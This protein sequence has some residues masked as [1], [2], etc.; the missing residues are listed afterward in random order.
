MDWQIDG[1]MDGTGR[2]K[3]SVHQ[4]HCVCLSVWICLWMWLFLCMIITTFPGC[5]LASCSLYRCVCVVTGT[6][7]IRV[8]TGLCHISPT[9]ITAKWSVKLITEREKRADCSLLLEITCYLPYKSWVS[10]NGAFCF[11]RQDESQSEA[12]CV[13]SQLR[14]IIDYFQKVVRTEALNNS[15]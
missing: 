8:P 14:W 2:F 13:L 10:P 1:L 6:V 7:T 3:Y 11:V 12:C 5:L 4:Y 9:E 15:Q